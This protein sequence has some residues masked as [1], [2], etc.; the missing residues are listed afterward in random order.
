MTVLNASEER[1]DKECDVTCRSRWFA[2]T[3]GVRQAAGEVF[4]PPDVLKELRC[5]RRRITAGGRSTVGM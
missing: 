2:R 3:Q 4:E 5:R 1:I